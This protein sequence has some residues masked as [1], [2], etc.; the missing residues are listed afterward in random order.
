MSIVPVIIAIVASALVFSSGFIFGRKGRGDIDDEKYLEAQATFDRETSEL[1][2][3]KQSLETALAMTQNSPN[4]G[5]I[6]GLENILAPIARTHS[7]RSKIEAIDTSGLTRNDLS[8]LLTKVSQ[9]CGLSKCVLVDP[10]GLPIAASKDATDIDVLAGLSAVLHQLALRTRQNGQPMPNA[11]I[12][13]D[14]ENQLTLARLIPIGEKYFTIL[15]ILHGNVIGPDALDPL[16]PV[17]RKVL[18]H[19]PWAA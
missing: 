13:R 14:E 1:R 8:L 4:P 18:R 16:V 17:I 6:E 2:E 11:F 5:A 10:G 3:A 9:S 12:H 19:E 15:A 7:I